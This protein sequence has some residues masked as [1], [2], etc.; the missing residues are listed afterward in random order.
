MDAL[1]NNFRFIVGDIV[2]QG[3]EIWELYLLVSK[4]TEI[5]SSPYI[6]KTIIKQLNLYIS[7]H[8]KLY[9][10]FFGDLK[11]KHHFLIH[12][13]RIIEKNKTS[14]LLIIYEI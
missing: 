13:P 3:N 4:I 8:H 5:V 10:S 6:P 12:Y 9:I 11:P 14:L 1:V 2:L 7:P